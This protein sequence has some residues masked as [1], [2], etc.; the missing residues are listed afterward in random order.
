MPCTLELQPAVLSPEDAR[1][2]T[3]LGAT[4]VG[5]GTSFV[6]VAPHAS[7]VD[8]CLLQTD[9]AGAVVSE[10]RVGIDRKSTRLNSSHW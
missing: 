2:R 1:D 4:P 8:L 5:D 7:A 3:R 9:G 10:R 6:V